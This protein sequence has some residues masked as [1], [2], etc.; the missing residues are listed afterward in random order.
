MTVLEGPRCEA[1]DSGCGLSI[2]QYVGDSAPPKVADDRRVTM[3]AVPGPVIKA[4]NMQCLCRMLTD[5]AKQC[6]VADRQEG[7]PHE[8]LSQIPHGSER[9]SIYLLRMF[10]EVLS[11]AGQAAV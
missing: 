3:A 2:S 5:D 1:G 9:I 7:P 8:T 11:Q 10:P 6:V 4:E